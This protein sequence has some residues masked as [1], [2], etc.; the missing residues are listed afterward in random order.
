MNQGL[1]TRSQV[2]GTRG[3]AIHMKTLLSIR[4]TAPQTRADRS[5]R[6]LDSVVPEAITRAG[7]QRDETREPVEPEGPRS[8]LLGHR[9]SQV[10]IT[11]S[12]PDAAGDAAGPVQAKQRAGMPSPERIHQAARHGISGAG[13]ALPFLGPIQRS[14]GRHDVTE[15]VAHTDRV[16]AEGARAMN[17]VAFNRGKHVAFA[18]Q[19]DLHT[20]AHEAAHAIQQ[21]SG[22]QLSDGVGRAGDR[23]EQHADAVAD[24][25]VK[26]ESAESM[27]DPYAAASSASAPDA[28]VQR[29]ITVK[30][31]QR[32]EANKLSDEEANKIYERLVAELQGTSEIAKHII[33]FIEKS[34]QSINVYIGPTGRNYYYSA[35][36]VYL[37]PQ[38]TLDGQDLAQGLL[39]ELGH[40]LQHIV[41][42][43]HY[44]SLEQKAS[45]GTKRQ[46]GMA[47]GVIEGSNAA[48]H[49]NATASERKLPERPN[50]DA[51]KANMKKGANMGLHQRQI[52]DRF[53]IG[54]TNKEDPDAIIKDI[55]K[56]LEEQKADKIALLLDLKQLV[57]WKLLEEG[58]RDTFAAAVALLQKMQTHFKDQNLF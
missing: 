52:I 47:I 18:G 35:M 4:E 51:N 1:G 55:K 42:G 7:S 3:V 30:G 50:Y 28:P 56:C 34:E 32:D 46:S 9:F 25:V 16:A 20:A 48:Y 37:D 15:L 40:A 11:P 43:E 24:Q 29:K 12:S 6:E 49:D 8:P 54:L 19:P 21:R 45:R 17:A 22:V 23:Y 27:L 26:G 38:I 33:E 36:G 5:A 39:H 31:F 57:M 41:G 14:F 53:L 13:G 58:D 10:A 44:V 2:P